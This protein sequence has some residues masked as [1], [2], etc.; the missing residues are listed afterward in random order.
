[1]LAALHS[2]L[3]VRNTISTYAQRIGIKDLGGLKKVFGPR[4][5][6]FLQGA[7]LGERLEG[8]VFPSF[9]AAMRS[10]DQS[11]LM[12]MAKLRAEKIIENMPS[13]RTV[14]LRNESFH[15][16]PIWAVPKSFGEE[17]PVIS[18]SA[19]TIKST[20]DRAR[21]MRL[22]AARLPFVCLPVEERS[23]LMDCGSAK[24]GD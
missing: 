4:W 1:M 20:E 22:Y 5:A 10:S 2:R 12:L 7:I 19:D 21:E 24:S 15:N 18:P 9:K 16:W 17:I 23:Y 6:Y 13:N 3:L 8:V 14:F 11:D